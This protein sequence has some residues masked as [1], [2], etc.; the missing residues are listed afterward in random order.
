MCGGVHLDLLHFEGARALAEEARELAR[1]LS[2]PLPVVSAGIDL[3]FNWARSGEAG[4][5]EGLIPEV[6]EAVATAQ[7]THG[8]LWRL[9]F[10]Q[11]RAESAA[12][13]G[14]WDDARLLAADALRRGLLTGRVK[15]VVAALGVQAKALAIGNQKRR[16][17]A[18][19]AEA[20]RLAKATADPSM[21]MRAAS[22]CVELEPDDLGT[23]AM[24]EAIDNILADLPAGALRERFATPRAY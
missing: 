9:R 10:A 18:I 21:T 15:Y 4:L 23:H 16:A 13:R 19:S 20:L 12:A 14:H 8:W 7:G 22:V 5:A 6:E 24:Q 11:A 3:I 2:F 1:S 17:L